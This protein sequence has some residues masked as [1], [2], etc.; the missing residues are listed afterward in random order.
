VSANNCRCSKQFRLFLDF[1]QQCPV[2]IFQDRKLV[3]AEPRAKLFRPQDERHPV[4][5]VRGQ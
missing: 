2:G 5:M 4:V 1:N 3:I